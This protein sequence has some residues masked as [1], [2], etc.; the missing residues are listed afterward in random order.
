MYGFSKKQIENK[1]EQIIDYS[2]LRKFI[3]NPVRTYSTGM[4]G[5]LAYAIMVNV[6]ADIMLVD[7]VLSTG[8]YAF[9]TKAIAHFK[10]LTKSGK[11]IVIV[12]HSI[13]IIQDLCT[14]VAWI[15]YGDLK[16]IG[17]AKSVCKHYLDELNNS[18][19][20][21]TE[22]A[23]SGDAYAQYRLGIMYR[24]GINV[25]K[26]I[27]RAFELFSSSMN[28]GNMDAQVCVA[29]MF[30][31]GLSVSK[32]RDHAISLLKM[33]AERGNDEAIRKLALVY[34]ERLREDIGKK[35]S[36]LYENHP[37]CKNSTTAA[38]NY[39]LFKEKTAFNEFERRDA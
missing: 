27:N 4:V 7:E 29:D 22:R 25:E 21:L 24:D 1:I 30:F 38:Y 2:N 33:A 5:R 31:Q 14:R 17:D 26:N 15:Q 20:L 13:D 23:D 10:K 3:D 35:I 8:D 36:D 6:E 37:A 16:T 34:N 9:S 32:N 12:S 28:A 18:I 11:T 19:E 39:A